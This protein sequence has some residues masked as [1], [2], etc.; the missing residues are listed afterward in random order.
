MKPGQFVRFRT[1]LSGAVVLALLLG[2]SAG[3]AGGFRVARPVSAATLT[4]LKNDLKRM[5]E[6]QDQVEA[7]MADIARQ[8]KALA[9]KG[10]QLEGDLQWLN[11]RTDE[12]RDAYEQLLDELAAAMQAVEQSIAAFTE[13]ERVLSDK[14]EQYRDRLVLMY[15]NRQRNP[16]EILLQS[17]G[18]TGFLANLRLLS[19]IADSD[20]RVLEDLSIARDDAVLK[21]ETAEEERRLAMEYVEAKKA[22]IEALKRQRE[23]TQAEIDRVRKA[24][25]ETKRQER[26]LQEESEQI[27]SQIVSLQTKIKYYGGKMVWPY[28]EDLTVGSPFGMRLHPIYRYRKMHNG[29]DLG[30]YYGAPIVAAADGKVILVRTIPGYNATKGNNTGGSQ[31]GNYLIIDHGGGI[32]TVYAHCKLLKVKVGQNVKAGQLVATCGSTGLSTGP[33]LHF[34]VREDGV[35]VN[36]IQ[37]K[38]LGNR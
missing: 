13:A 36:P 19:L 17:D 2:A 29:V 11:E 26:L 21:R 5:Q 25:E 35:P 24:V 27:E 37:S 16:V 15:M 14:H 22:E 12:E 28:P 20:R 33:H 1:L 31:Y 18:M 23:Q 4:D 6:Q 7:E 3:L 30:G 8:K 32:S 38:Y 10:Q 9:K 34:E